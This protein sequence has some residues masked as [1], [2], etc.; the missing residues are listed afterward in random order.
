MLKENREKV[1]AEDA[2]KVDEALAEMKKAVESGG[3]DA[4]QQAMDKMNA[5]SHKLAEAMY[6]ASSAQ[7]GA[8]AGGPQGGTGDGA[9]ASGGSKP[10]DDVVDAEFVDVDEKNK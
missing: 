2:A 6:K 4:I 3:K 9:G 8:Q 1:G 5:A 7:A 10:K